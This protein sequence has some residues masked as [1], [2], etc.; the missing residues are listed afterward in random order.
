MHLVINS[1]VNNEVAL[2]HLL[3]TLG[4][5]E[6]TAVVGGCGG[7]YTTMRGQCKIVNVMYNAIDFNGLLAILDGAVDV[8]EQFFYIHDT[9]CAGPDFVRKV[10]ELQCTSSASFLFPSMNIGVYTR[11]LL[12]K[13]RDFLESFRQC[14]DVQK[15]KARCVDTEDFIFKTNAYHTF[16]SSGPPFVQGPVDYYGSGVQRIVEYYNAMDLYKIKANWTTKP[17]YQLQL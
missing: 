6:C 17:L 15:N 11:T 14:H 13:N 8:P 5:F 16:I 9:M 10:S 1:H 12:E 3:E 2:E 7:N 4:G